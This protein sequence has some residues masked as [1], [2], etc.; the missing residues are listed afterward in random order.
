M[1]KSAAELF[2]QTA[3]STDDEIYTMV[4]L[5]PD[6]IETATRVLQVLNQPVSVLI[7]DR[8]E[9]TLAVPLDFWQ[10][11]ASDLPHAL[12]EGRF[13]LITFESVLAFDVVGFMAHVAH[14]LTE[15][16]I[17]ILP[18]AAFSRDHLLIAEDRFEKAWQALHNA[19]LN[20]S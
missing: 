16:G 4:K 18:F 2:R 5:P 7:A 14:I 6:A 17:S 8:Y 9:I 10:L 19:Q 13:R 3:I 11:H 1:N 12:S 15:V 20:G